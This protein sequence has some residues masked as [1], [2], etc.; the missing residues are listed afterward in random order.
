MNNIKPTEIEKLLTMNK[1]DLVLHILLNNVSDGKIKKLHPTDYILGGYYDNI[2]TEFP[3]LAW[4]PS[5]F[6]EKFSRPLIR[7]TCVKLG[8]KNFSEIEE[9]KLLNFYTELDKLLQF[10]LNMKDLDKMYYS[11]KTITREDEESNETN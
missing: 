7:L 8:Y 3:N 5:E 10:T 4:T 11:N 9:N 6:T 2:K 1:R